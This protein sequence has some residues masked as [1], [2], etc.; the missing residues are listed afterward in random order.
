MENRGNHFLGNDMI[1]IQPLFE[2]IRNSFTY[3]FWVKPESTIQIPREASSGITGISGQRYV[4]GPGHAGARENAGVGVSIG[5][6]GIAVYEHT[7][8]YLSALLV[9]PVSI[10]DW[11]HIAV[12]Y[13]NKTPY[14]YING[15]LVKKGLRSRKV[16]VYPSGYLGGHDYGYYV[17]FI[18]EIKLWNYTRSKEEIKNSMQE[19]L[20]E[21]KYGLIGCWKFH[22]DNS[23]SFPTALNPSYTETG[24]K[25]LNILF[26]KSG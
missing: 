16:N 7:T 24:R 3:E 11:T 2:N 19:I 17:G 22:D 20:T 10:I 21:N 15:K 18:K 13:N 6:N 25:N 8:N 4:I 1:L 5:T 14:L 12:V 9:F 26:V 23:N